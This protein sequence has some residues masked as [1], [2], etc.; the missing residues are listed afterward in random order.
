MQQPK[1]QTLSIGAVFT[2]PKWATFA[3]EKFGLLEKWLAGKTILDPTMGEGNLLI[4]L[5]EAGLETG[6]KLADLPTQNLYGIELNTH[7]FEAFCSKIEKYNF[8]QTN[9]LN[10]DFFF[11]KTTVEVDIIFGNPPWQTFANLPADYKEIAKPLFFEYD[12]V[13]KAQDLLLGGS[14]MDIASLVIQK[15][16]AKHLK[17]NGEAI[18]FMPLSLLLNDGANETFRNYKVG[19]THFAL[20]KIYDFGTAKI[21]ENVATRYGLV[22]FRRDAFTQY[23]VPY[24][25]LE[26]ASWQTLFARPLLRENAPLSVTT[27]E[28]INL[29]ET[30]ALFTILPTQIPR[31]GVNTGG[32]N[33]IFFFQSCES[34]DKENYILNEKIILPKKF[35]YPLITSKNFQKQAKPTKWVLLPYKKKGKPLDWAEIEK[36]PHLQNYLWQHKIT[37]ENRKG[38]MLNAVMKKGYW[39]A[40][41][42]VGKYNFAP[43]KVVWESYGRNTFEPQ[44]F[45]S[46][47]Q[48]NQ[49]LQ[50][51][52]P[53]ETKELAE[54]ILA[55]LQ[56]PVIE[57]Y[58]LSLKME[59]TMNWAQA[60]KIKSL[61]KIE[62]TQK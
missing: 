2:P 49:S 31:Q 60:G 56:N 40:M 10:E 27:G 13:G 25:R 14:R 4:S 36:Y 6:R 55:Y 42:G 7:Y 58:L 20:E 22:Y 62:E 26:Q 5:V 53:C 16:I 52:V 35:I 15:S 30:L 8:K 61:F 9:F 46:R 48:A 45:K 54:K 17:T 57:T 18:F 39:W 38:T 19:K 21:F 11:T 1:H 12:L 59:G 37:L 23:P 33:D 28:N 29:L 44:I 43:Y 24:L 34:F 41:L 50:C 47:W 32:A 3:I 51:F